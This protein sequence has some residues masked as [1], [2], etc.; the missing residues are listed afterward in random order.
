MRFGQTS[1]K[2]VE[3]IQSLIADGSSVDVRVRCKDHQP[4]D[5]LGAHKLILAA[6]SPTYLKDI[7]LNVTSEDELI[8]LHLPD[9][10]SS[11]VG[12]VMSL[13]Y[14][15]EIWLSESYVDICES[16]L[17]DL[18]IAVQLEKTGPEFSLVP[19]ESLKEKRIRIKREP[20]LSSSSSLNLEQNCKVEVFENVVV[21]PNLKREL[22]DIDEETVQFEPFNDDP[23]Q[24]N[25]KVPA[26]NI[27]LEPPDSDDNASESLPTTPGEPAEVPAR[28]KVACGEPGCSY[29]TSSLSSLQSHRLVHG[30][31]N[32][33][34]LQ[35]KTCPAC[36]SVHQTPKEIRSHAMECHAE[37][38]D[39]SILKCIIEEFC[40]WQKP[41]ELDGLDLSF[42]KHLTDSHTCD[43]LKVSAD[44]ANE[45]LYCD[46]TGCDYSTLKGYNLTQHLRHHNDERGHQCPICGKSFRSSSHLRNH[47]RAVHTKERI[48]QCPKCPRSFATHWQSKSHQKSNHGSKRSLYTC[49]ICPKQYQTPQALAGHMK[50]GHAANKKTSADGK[51][52]APFGVCETCGETLLNKSH[53]CSNVQV[54]NT[55]CSICQKMVDSKALKA[56][57]QYHRKKE[58]SSFV[59][60]FCNKSF[61]TGISLKRHLLIHQNAKPFNCKICE[62]TFRQNG[63]LKAH[64]RIHSGVRFN[65]T[66]CGKRFITK[67]LLNQH[68]KAVKSCRAGDQ[69]VVDG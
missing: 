61:T 15:G 8:C 20:S 40:D 63:A 32:Q 64:E 44:E 7:L 22:S 69:K 50:S 11:Q 66:I 67:S 18:K 4:S 30:R 14:Y 16:I 62:K 5:G 36:K 54:E 37:I 48:F 13:L 29:S 41:L 23:K 21:K 68:V 9:Y 35:K 26:K 31:R 39:N 52:K 3:A 58:V 19:R 42:I 25:S 27:K 38:I 6:A 24:I 45:E 2:I 56:H 51:I 43:D 1:S 33:R 65:C 53:Q 34:L 55:K 60:Q 57:M 59:C 10:T 28:P 12:P 47:T 17:K 46:F 49:K